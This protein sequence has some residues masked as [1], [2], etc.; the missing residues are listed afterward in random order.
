[1]DARAEAIVDTMPPLSD[2]QRALLALLF[3]DKTVK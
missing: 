3:R 2:E 1:M